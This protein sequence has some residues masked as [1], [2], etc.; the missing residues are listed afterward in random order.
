M[1]DGRFIMDVATTTIYSNIDGID[2]RKVYNSSG[3][4]FDRYVLSAWQYV[5][6]LK[7]CA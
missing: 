1:V 2:D 3:I 4:G 5:T 6:T 7:L